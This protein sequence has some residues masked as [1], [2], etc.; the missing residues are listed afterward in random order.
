MKHRVAAIVAIAFVLAAAGSAMAQGAQNDVAVTR[1][2]IQAD[3]QAIVSHN[4]KLT[5]AQASAFWPVYR[6]YRN[7]LAK[8]GDRIVKLVSDY[9]AAYDTL[10]DAQATSMMTEYMS[11]QKDTLKVKDK[12]ISKFSGVLPPK[13]VMRF[14]QIENKID[15]ILM[16]G[17]VDG[18]PLAK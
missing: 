16:A 11:I 3:R 13:L 4:M 8:Q 6:E 5:D 14:Y 1:S 12:Y 17:A 9:G 7:E 2:D 15:T 10:T 18:V